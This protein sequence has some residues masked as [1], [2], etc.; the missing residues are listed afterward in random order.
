MISCFVPSCAVSSAVPEQQISNVVPLVPEAVLRMLLTVEL[1]EMGLALAKIGTADVLE[2]MVELG[3]VVLVVVVV[4]VVE[5]VLVKGSVTVVGEVVVVV[6]VVVV[7]ASSNRVVPTSSSIAI[8]PI[9]HPK[10]TQSDSCFD[11]S[12]YPKESN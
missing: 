7:S 8:A 4:I 1:L 6:V 9:K 2:V 3:T 11:A 5:G 10:A 12:F